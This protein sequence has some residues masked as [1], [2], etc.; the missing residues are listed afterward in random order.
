[1]E[2]ITIRVAGPY[3]VTTDG[4]DVFVNGEPA[5]LVVS[6]AGGAVQD[7]TGAIARSADGEIIYGVVDTGLAGPDGRHVLIGL[8]SAQLEIYTTARAQMGG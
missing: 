3:T 2:P 5:M 7:N 1:M 4:A 6:P 8:T